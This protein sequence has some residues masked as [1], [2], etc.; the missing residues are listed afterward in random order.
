MAS[1]LPQGCQEN[2][3]GKGQLLQQ[4]ESGKLDIH[5]QKREIRHSIYV[6]H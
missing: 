6:L 4:M 2:T 1:D 5:M 3:T